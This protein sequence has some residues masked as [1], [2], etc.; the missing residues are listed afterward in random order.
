[1]YL[2]LFCARLPWWPSGKK[3]KKK[4]P[5]A[6]AGDM[7]LILGSG[8]FIG[9]G[10]GNPLQSSCLGN[11]MDRGGWWATALGVA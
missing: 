4:N 6:K 5:P 3:K 9:K 8:R 10:S 2:M 11:H 1:M 7:D